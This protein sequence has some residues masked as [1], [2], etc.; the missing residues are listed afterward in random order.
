[1][2]QY[3]STDPQ[4]GRK[5]YLSTDPR[6]GQ[7]KGTR[8]LGVVSAREPGTRRGGFMKHLL[9]EEPA[10]LGALG[11]GAAMAA[12]LFGVGA[13]VAGAASA[14]APLAGHVLTRG[15]RAVTGQAQ[16]PVSAEEVVGSLAGP[17]LPY[18][19]AVLGKAGR[20][21]AA[22][23]HVQ[24]AFGALGG[25]SLLG[26][27]PGIGA[28]GGAVIGGALGKHAVK[29]AATSLG[30]TRPAAHTLADIGGHIRGLAKRLFPGS[31]KSVAAT[32]TDDTVRMV[33]QKLT[34]QQVAQRL[35]TEYGARKGG[36]MLYGP[37][38]RRADPGAVTRT[39][40]ARSQ[41]VRDV[42]APRQGRHVPRPQGDL[43]ESV[44][45]E[46]RAKIATLSPEDAYAYA[47][48]ANNDIAREYIGRLLQGKS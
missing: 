45:R 43:P 16:K 26:A 10:A 7:K 18:G 38:Q 21:I 28:F 8:S 44:K 3:L 33:R 34:P 24:R 48:R 32:A 11:T 9:S 6:A 2:P 47:Q 42:A 40:A 17:L 14:A 29:A 12:P 27:L 5:K 37:V 19:G 46:I 39:E 23:P 22:H 1:M 25:A 36:R 4:A 31:P 15:V 20:L 41:A 13:G 30:K 35:E